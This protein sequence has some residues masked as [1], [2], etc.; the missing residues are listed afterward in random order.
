[1]IKYKYT[2]QN[3]IYTRGRFC[4]FF[5]AYHDKRFVSFPTPSRRRSKNIIEE[6]HVTRSY[7]FNDARMQ[8]IFFTLASL[9]LST[10]LPAMA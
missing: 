3:Q 7:K 4:L 5:V 6:T 2:L 10:I 1:M 8:R 9:A